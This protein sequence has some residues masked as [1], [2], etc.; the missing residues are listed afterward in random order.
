M[1]TICIEKFHWKHSIVRKKGHVR[2]N[3]TLICDTRRVIWTDLNFEKQ[4]DSMS[5]RLGL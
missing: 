4:F 2:K 3:T 5:F 1:A